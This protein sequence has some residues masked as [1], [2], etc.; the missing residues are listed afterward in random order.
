[1]EELAE[2]ERLIQNEQPQSSS[3]VCTDGPTR[4]SVIFN[5]GEDSH[6][7]MDLFQPGSGLTDSGVLLT[8]FCKRKHQLREGTV[9]THSAAFSWFRFVLL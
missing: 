6:S 3:A 2:A 4:P 8:H 5:Y 7:S 1:M 9:M